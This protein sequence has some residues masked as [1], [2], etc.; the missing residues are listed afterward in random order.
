MKVCQLCKQDGHNSADCPDDPNKQ[1]LVSLPD[2]PAEQ[3]ALLDEVLEKIY[4]YHC[5]TAEQVNHREKALENLQSFMVAHFD[6][7]CELKLFGSSR[8][9]FG[10]RGSDMDLCLTFKNH[11]ENP[12][13]QFS[14]AVQVIKQLS[15][16]LKKNDSFKNVVP[17]TAAK[18]PIVKFEYYYRGMQYEGDISYYNVLA[19]RNTQL[20]SL[21]ANLDNRCQ[22]LG[23]VLKALV[24]ECGI[25]DASRGSL[26]SYAY[27]L[28][29]IHYLQ[30]VE[31]LPVLQEL[32]EGDTQPVHTVEG[33]NTWFQADPAIIDKLF[34]C[35]NSES[36]ARIWIGFL[37]YYTED[38]QFDKTTI[39]IRHKSQLTTFEKEWTSKCISIEDPFELT[40]NLGCGVS[41]KMANYI[42]KVFQRARG[43]FGRFD[44]NIFAEKNWE[45]NLDLYAEALFS[46]SLLT[47]GDEVPNDR[48]CRICGKIGHFVKDC[49]LSRQNRNKKANQNGGNELTTGVQILSK[50]YACNETG[51]FAKKCPNKRNGRKQR[52]NDEHLDQP[53]P[54][55]TRGK[56]DNDMYR[57]SPRAGPNRDRWFERRMN[58]ENNHSHMGSLRVVHAPNGQPGGVPPISENAA[59][60]KNFFNPGT[61]G[62]NRTRLN[63][64]TRKEYHNRPTMR[65][66]TKTD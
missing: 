24:K 16:V 20:L 18:V 44:A 10:F 3:Y 52:G 4:V 42:V 49:P 23:Y 55:R 27:V 46:A 66:R 21:Y 22:K 41:R 14:N 19:Q 30:Q 39:Q 15:D 65:P 51:H 31:V 34:K 5:P 9:G 32:Y 61:A 59:I 26:S 40:H 58:Q 37:Q 62:G 13:P 17:I 45:F 47:D 56:L 35:P 43:I 38:F 29:L 2:L 60:R 7:N 48:C 33:F 53:S 25:G 28:L 64:D 50:C 11:D 36:L 57:R 6:V 8:N 1:T 54:N 63:S 12:P